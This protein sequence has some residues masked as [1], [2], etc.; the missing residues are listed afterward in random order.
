[1]DLLRLFT[2]MLQPLSLDE[3][4]LDVSSVPFDSGE[5]LGRQIKC[6]IR[7]ATAL[8]ASLGLAPN[9]L[10]AKVASDIQKPDG[11]TLVPAGQEQNFLAPL[12][13]RKLWG[14]GP[15]AEGRL[16]S[17]GIMTCGQLAQ[18]EAASVVARFGQAGLEWQRLARG[19]DDRKVTSV[20]ERR[21]L[22]RERTFAKDVAE[23]E[24]LHRIVA[25]IAE[26]V[27]EDLKEHR[28]A[29]TVTLKLRYANFRTV[30]RGHSPGHVITAES[31]L[32]LS[33]WLLEKNWNGKPVRLLGI[34]VSNF[35]EGPEGQPALF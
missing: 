11:L 23:R 25:E 10:V 33:R 29:R 26:H 8:T 27:G 30:T 35:L 24:E 13:V 34:G 4:F 14:I 21:T 20:W 2:R 15:Q 6:R 19:Q 12:P 1:M 3:A 28:P 32:L 9:V 16:R 18:A 31:L 17:S 22:S 5:L 7:E